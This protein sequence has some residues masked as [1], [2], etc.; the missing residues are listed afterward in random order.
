MDKA[1]VNLPRP[2]AAYR[3]GVRNFVT[4]SLE[5][6]GNPSKIRCPC[7]RCRNLDY[8]TSDDVVSHLVI[9]G[10]DK[11]YDVWIFHGEERPS[12]S[13]KMT[14]DLD[15]ISDTYR[16]FIDARANEE[17]IP[18]YTEA[19]G[20]EGFS[21]LLEDAETPL[22][23]GC[24]DYTKMTATVVLFKHKAVNGIS[25]KAF[26][27]LLKIIG[28]MLPQKNVLPSSTY[29]A[30]KLLKNFDLGYE[31]IHACA[32]DC[33]LFRKDLA[34]L[35]NCP[36]CGKSRWKVVGKG[37]E[38]KIKK[39]VP[40]KGFASKEKANSNMASPHL[41]SIGSRDNLNEK[42][43][44][45]SSHNGSSNV[46]DCY[47]LNSRDARTSVAVDRKCK[48]LDWRKKVLA[49]AIIASTDPNAMVHGVP[50]GNDAWKVWVQVALVPS[51]DLWRPNSDMS[52]IADAVGSTTAWP[53]E[54]V[55]FNYPDKGGGERF[56]R[57]SI[58]LGVRM[59]DEYEASMV[60]SASDFRTQIEDR[61]EE[62][63]P[64][65]VVG[66]IK[67]LEGEISN[68]H[69]VET[70][71]VEVR[72]LESCKGAA[73]RSTLRLISSSHYVLHSKIMEIA[74]M[75]VFKSLELQGSIKLRQW[76]RADTF[77]RDF[78]P[79]AYEMGAPLS[80]AIPNFLCQNCKY[81][82]HECFICGVLGSSDK[83][84][85]APEGGTVD[86]FVV[87]SFGSAYQAVFI[88]LIISKMVLPAF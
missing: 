69:S 20:D 81:K 10:M 51:A 27:D 37:D 54:F 40:A 8:Q 21:K 43:P 80:A 18:N 71:V 7:T 70:Y 32:N 42:S 36:R 75:D 25:H 33:C 9:Y 29:S 73:D 47:G 35:D 17:T 77:P 85:G 12:T 50:L 79:F 82:Q 55:S 61:S 38:R 67:A 19:M 58:R 5:S 46:R 22:Y 64:R 2:T 14:C 74:R 3:E 16:M 84:P 53:K 87:N 28:H 23:M 52:V 6:L 65:G 68:A 57:W 4:V 83:S 39:G 72:G 88:C 66:M 63:P 24:S 45:P 49:E 56:T 44:T 62:E 34:N 41:H 59:F 30:K 13:S 60:F 15:D 11:T 26:T 78:I 1:W 48:L 86:L 76:V 31:K